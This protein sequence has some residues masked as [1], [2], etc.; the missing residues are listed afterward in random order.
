[1]A[2]Q[3]VI[4]QPRRAIRLNPRLLEATN[5]AIS[6]DREGRVKLPLIISCRVEVSTLPQ[7]LLLC[8]AR[9]ARIRSTAG[10]QTCQEIAADPRCLCSLEV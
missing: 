8:V 1:M 10:G 2:R 9:S 3:L 7:R 4:D 5:T 6:A